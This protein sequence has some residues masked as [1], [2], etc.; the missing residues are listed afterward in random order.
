MLRITNK[1]EAKTMLKHISCDCE[2][3]FNS[4]TCFSNQKW[5][6]ET[7]PCECKSYC[8]CKKDY[9]W[10][11]STCIF[12]NGKYWKSIVDDS[13]IVCDECYGYI[14]NK[15]DKHCNNKCVNK[16]WW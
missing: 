8:T 9:S 12:E 6:N 1:T 4:A 10:N 15:N 7:C 14:I 2:C 16:F 3:K 5:N 11:P 13:K